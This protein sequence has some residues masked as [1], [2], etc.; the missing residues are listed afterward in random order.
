MGGAAFKQ[1]MLDAR[2]R[3]SKVGIEEHESDSE[4]EKFRKAQI[5]IFPK[6]PPPQFWPN[7]FQVN[8]DKFQA[9]KHRL[10]LPPILEESSSPDKAEFGFDPSDKREQGKRGNDFDSAIRD[11]SMNWMEC[12]LRCEG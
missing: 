2:E 3:E 10:T 7:Q 5:R 1:E 11:G 6:T 4:W 12:A 8:N 9:R